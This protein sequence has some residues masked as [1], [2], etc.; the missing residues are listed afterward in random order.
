[1]TAQFIIPLVICFLAVWV[2]LGDPLGTPK[3]LTRLLASF[4]GVVC[5]LWFFVAAP[6]VLQ[7]GFTVMLLVS[8]NFFSKTVLR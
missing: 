4:V 6:W 3:E 8:S 7:L 5:G 1:M 2:T